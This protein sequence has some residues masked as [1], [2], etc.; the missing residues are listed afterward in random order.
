LLNAHNLPL[1]SRTSASREQ[2]QVSKWK[3]LKR[4]QFRIGTE[5]GAV[6]AYTALHADPTLALDQHEGH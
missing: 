5:V 1:R 2:S 3:P 6:F 4:Q